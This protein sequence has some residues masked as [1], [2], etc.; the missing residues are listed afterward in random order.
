MGLGQQF[1]ALSQRSKLLVVV[2]FV[3]GS[4]VGYYFGWQYQ[5]QLPPYSINKGVIATNISANQPSITSQPLVSRPRGSIISWQDAVK[6]IRNCQVVTVVQ[7]HQNEIILT[8]R[9]GSNVT[10]T[11]PTI[12]MVVK[13][14][15][16]VSGC[17][18]EIQ[19]E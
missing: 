5:A 1:A 10:A 19:I 8:L 12:D 13:E 4:A 7:T 17:Q 2:F 16:G 6:L 15:Q 11:E 18:V 9:D 3:M 14:V